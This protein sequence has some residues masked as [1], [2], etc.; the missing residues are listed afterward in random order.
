MDPSAQQFETLAAFLGFTPATLQQNLNQAAIASSRQNAKDKMMRLSKAQFLDLSTDVTDEI[1]RRNLDQKDVPFLALSD[2]YLPKRNQARQKLATLASSKFKELATDIFWDLERRFPAAAQQY[3]GV[4]AASISGSGNSRKGSS[5]VGDGEVAVAVDAMMRGSEGISPETVERLRSEYENR[6]EALQVRIVKME[7]DQRTAKEEQQASFDLL[8]SEQSAKL[9]DLEI[10]HNKLKEEHSKLQNKH[11][12]L[13]DDYSNQ[14]QI[15]SDIRTE[16]TNLLEEIKTLTQKNEDLQAQIS[17]K[18]AGINTAPRESAVLD[19]MRLQAYYDGVDNLLVASRSKTPTS[20]LVAMKSIVIACK[21]ITEDAELY[22]NNNN[23]NQDSRDALEAT[24]NNLSQSLTELMA[25]AKSHATNYGSVAPGVLEGA[26]DG[27]TAVVGELVKVLKEALGLDGVPTNVVGYEIDQL[28]DYLEKQTDQI[29]QAIQ[30]LLGLMR[31]SQT[32]GPEFTSTVTQIIN[33]VSSIC[34]VSAATMSKP[35]AAGV[36]SR[37]TEILLDLKDANSKIGELGNALVA[38]PSSKALKQRIA[39]SSYEIAK[40]VKELISLIASLA[41]GTFSE[42]FEKLITACLLQ[43]L[44]TA[45]FS[46]SKECVFLQTLNMKDDKKRIY[47]HLLDAMR[48][49]TYRIKGLTSEKGKQLNGLSVEAVGHDR[50]QLATSAETHGLGASVPVAVAL[51]PL[52]SQFVNVPLAVLKGNSRIERTP[53][54]AV[55]QLTLPKRTPL[56]FGWGGG[57]SKRDKSVE[58]D[59]AVG[60]ELGVREGDKAT[61]SLLTNIPKA[62]SVNVAPATADD[63]E[64]LELHAEHLET[65][66]LRQCRVVS[67]G[68]PLL[69]WVRGQTVIK[70]NVVSTSPEAP[71]L[72]LDND[73]EII[74]APISRSSPNASMPPSSAP[75]RDVSG[76]NNIHPRGVSARIIRLEDVVIPSDLSKALTEPTLFF[77]VQDEG[78][79]SPMKASQ[80]TLKSLSSFSNSVKHVRI[81]PWK[82]IPSNDPNLDESNATSGSAHAAG[83]GTYHVELIETDQIPAGCVAMSLGMRNQM[84]VSVCQRIRLMDPKQ[85]A[86]NPFKIVVKKLDGDEEAIV[87]NSKSSS[88]ESQSISTLFRTHLSTCPTSKRGKIILSSNTRPSI[89]VDGATP[90]RVLVQIF[91][92]DD[93]N[94]NTVSQ[95]TWAQ[96]RREDVDALEILE[97]DKTGVTGVVARVTPDTQDVN[98]PPMGGADKSIQALSNLVESRMGMKG[99]KGYIE[100]PALGGILVHGNPG[101]GKTTLIRHVLHRFSHDVEALTYSHILSCATLKDKKIAQIKQAISQAFAVSAFQAPSVVV[102][103]DLDLI[104]PSNAENADALG[105]RQIAEH[106]ILLVRRYCIRGGNGVTVIVTAADKQAIHSR[107]MASHAIADAVHVSAPNRVQRAEI[108]KVLVKKEFPS[109]QEIDT[110]PIASVTEGYRPTDLETLITRA[111]HETAVRRILHPTSTTSTIILEDLEKAV[112]GYTPAALKGLKMAEGDA[113]AVGWNDIG[114]LKGPKRMLVET[115]EW[116][117]RYARIFESCPL[118]LRSGILL[119]GYPGCGKTILAAAV[120]KEC[121][122]NFISVKGPEIL[123]KY[124]GESEKS[125]RDLFDRAQS[126]KPC[127]LF[128]DEF[129]SIA[130]RRGNDNTG[131]TDRVVNQLLTQMDGAEGL[132]GVY[133]LAATSR[134]DLIDPA[135]LRPGRLDKSVLCG[136]PDV[137]ERREILEAVSRKLRISES[138]DLMAYAARCEDFTGAD[139]QG[140]IYSAQLEAIHEQI[141]DVGVIEK[142]G[143]GVDNRGGDEFTIVQPV[144]VQKGMIGAERTKMKSR[145]QA[146]QE[147]MHT[148]HPTPTT[149]TVSKSAKSPLVII[150]PRHFEAALKVTRAS[151]NAQEK[152]RF[153]GVYAEFSGEDDEEAVVKAMMKR[154]GKKSTMA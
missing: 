14:Q 53:S 120:A 94:V 22:E 101:L 50:E 44:L 102:L 46:A 18:N 128:F 3:L 144:G 142:K 12:A 95:W 8:I 2:Q 79:E 117:T 55:F 121:G 93:P 76:I 51:T 33:I 31:Q 48:G 45:H 70:L 5:A 57:I 69:V 89:S 151:L 147:N 122:L 83:K 130:P 150:E 20:V 52:Q 146:I 111:S 27:L 1:K 78:S 92:K 104:A 109:T 71:V 21:N 49:K 16:A 62:A 68:Q 148:A 138:L 38:S 133:V 154:M 152:Q 9:Q 96:F 112:Q 90:T 136:M 26:V 65:E 56:F 108:L 127:I 118:R 75:E 23:L 35:S 86:T 103:D 66:F 141:G 47:N 114:G 126:A 131:V 153:D 73:S 124:I 82:M 105:S 85:P 116:P 25:A 59:V 119:Y 139:L 43:M 106:V 113:S 91:A 99:L 84:G 28:K 115:M 137:E 125:I 29:V 61:L 107:F 80:T 81:V 7:K 36:R 15:A 32:F 60:K 67:V 4:S 63:W 17:M 97:G 58:V 37:G 39:S 123:N 10:E 30:S 88:D 143:K 77:G 64:I 110:M 40:F 19:K 145:I 41:R 24:K 134:P 42:Y 129:D 11:E 98:C 132:D 72:R 100:A 6:I 87:F 34:Q 54:L 13:Q 135:L 140:L 74:V 149:P